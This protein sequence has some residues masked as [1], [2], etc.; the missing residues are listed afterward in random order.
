MKEKGEKS[1]GFLR[2][3]NLLPLPL[4]FL[5]LPFLPLP[6]PPPLLL[7]L[8]FFLS[9]IIGN[10]YI[11]LKSGTTEACNFKKKNFFKR[12]NNRKIHVNKIISKLC[13]LE[14][15]LVILYLFEILFFMNF[16]EKSK[17][18]Y[19][20]NIE[21]EDFFIRICDKMLISHRIIFSIL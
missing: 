13:P 6:L 17:N 5:P 8:P 16:Q 7:P 21:V 11:I 1:N 18:K 10:L 12:R 19:L 15:F 3:M 4:P 14:D 2:I 20:E 9:I